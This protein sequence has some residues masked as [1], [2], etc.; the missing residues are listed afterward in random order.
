[1]PAIEG[2]D[3]PHVHS[4]RSGDDRGVNGPEWKVSVGGHE[5]GDAEPVRRGD[6]L[7][8][9]VPR[10]KVTDEAHLGIGSDARTQEVGDLGDDQL[11]N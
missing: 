3:L 9:E 4:L 10:G 1:M 8:D 11:G 6:R 7:W 5:F 2:S